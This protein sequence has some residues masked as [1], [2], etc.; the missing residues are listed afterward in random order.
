MGKLFFVGGYVRDKLLYGKETNDRDLVLLPRNDPHKELEQTIKQLVDEGFKLVFRTPFLT[1]KLVKGELTYDIAVARRE[2]YRY[3]GA[4]PEVEPVYSLE[5]DALRRD[6]TVNAIY[7]D[8]QGRIYDPLGGTNHLR[9]KLLKPIS[10]FVDDPT[11]ILRGIRYAKRFKLR[12]DRLFLRNVPS[13]RKYF[14]YLSFDRVRKELE[15]ITSERDRIHMWRDVASMKLFGDALFRE[16]LAR[17]NDLIPYEG[18]YWIVFYLSMNMSLDL[19]KHLR[20][21]ERRLVQALKYEDLE[22]LE[23]I[24]SRMRNYDKF[25]SLVLFL[26]TG[27]KVFLKYFFKDEVRPKFSGDVQSFHRLWLENIRRLEPI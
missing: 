1:A 5:E 7:M 18:R 11:R 26:R 12:Y 16:T 21:Y 27:R 3:P 23:D 14:R 20:R 8:M 9:K 19:L 17:Y 24:H 13:G 10:S 22:T 15:K 2:T 6:F 4:L 25:A